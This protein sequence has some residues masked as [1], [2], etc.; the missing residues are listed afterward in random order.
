M[1]L[2]KNKEVYN[3]QKSFINLSKIK[4][5]K[6]D[7]DFQIS[8]IKNALYE[9]NIKHLIVD[10]QNEI[11]NNLKNDLF[12]KKKKNSSSFKITDTIFKE[13]ELTE[14]KDLLKYLLHR[15][16]YDIYPEILK[17]DSYP[18]YMQIEPTSIC[19]YR[20]VFCFQT[21][22]EFTDKKSGYMGKMSLDTYKE[23]IDQCYG[24]VEFIS[25]ASR[26]EPLSNPLIDK[27]LEYSRGKFL[28]LKINTNASL[29]NEKKIHAILRNDVRT[30]VFS[31]DAADA[32]LYSKLRVR[33]NLSKVLK[34]IELFNNIK[35][36]QYSGAK[37]ITRVSGVKVNE[38]QNF[39]EMENL[40]KNLVDQVVF[41]DYCP[42]EDVYND[43]INQ[44]KKPCS[45][46]WRRMYVWWDGKT[47]PCEV[48]FK[49]ILSAGNIFNQ[50]ISS[51]WKSEKYESLR[52]NHLMEKRGSINPCDKCVSI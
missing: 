16:R 34:N 33:G 30:L 9:N 20:C 44:I 24:N 13:I 52:K 11:I 5:E 27:M 14:K 41:V 22:K 38:F 29:L 46:L 1:E 15:Y 18:P 21:N 51:I 19:N 35:E 26:G 42:W 48:D 40:W 32:D 37:I 36:K 12:E 23:T 28:N 31:A 50:N 25:L 4:V 2:K 47:N 49:S 6:E 10:N 7:F 43:K 45:E 3:K 17:A 8:R 39:K